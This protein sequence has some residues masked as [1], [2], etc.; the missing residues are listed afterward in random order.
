MADLQRFLQDR[1]LSVSN[2]PHKGRSLFTTR[3]IRPG[4][5]LLCRFRVSL[6]QC[7]CSSETNLSHVFLPGEV[8]LS[9]KPYI[10]V[11]NNTS[12]E[13]RCDGCFKTNNLKKCS[14]CQVVWYCGS[15]CQVYLI[16]VLSVEIQ[17]MVVSIVRFVVCFWLFFQKSEWKLHRH[18][19]K[20]L[21]RLEK[22]KRKFVTPTIRLMVKLYI[23]RNLQNEKVIISYEWCCLHSRL[24]A[25]R[26]FGA[27]VLYVEMWRRSLDHILVLADSLVLCFI[28]IE[29]YVS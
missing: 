28:L 9:Q 6:E 1:C 20:A 18:E 22:E 21:T 11:P 13:S 23:K 3:D 14:G 19:C 25:Y 16:W 4:S 5:S 27:L 10:C 29:V 2:L 12:L 15:S 17:L 26:L 24:I 8:I 7:F